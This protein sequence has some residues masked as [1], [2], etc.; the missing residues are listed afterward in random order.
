MTL[1]GAGGKN[2]TSAESA[3]VWV[4]HIGHVGLPLAQMMRAVVEACGE[5][6]VRA[7]HDQATNVDKRAKHFYSI[8][9]SNSSFRVKKKRRT[10]QNEI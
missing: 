10:K 8:F 3:S 9:K 5:A 2:L 7:Q 1:V 6:E 4:A